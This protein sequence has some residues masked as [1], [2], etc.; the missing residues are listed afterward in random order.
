MT[1]EDIYFLCTDLV[2]HSR[3]IHYLSI[4]YYFAV[5]RA[6]FTRW[7]FQSMNYDTIVSHTDH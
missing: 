5:T 4:L 7:E 3:I 1:M 2:V 6:L